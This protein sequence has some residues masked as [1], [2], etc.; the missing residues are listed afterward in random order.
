MSG[1]KY[2][3]VRYWHKAEIDDLR[4]DARFRGKSG[5]QDQTRLFPLMTQGRPAA[6]EFT[7]R[8]ARA[9]SSAAEPRNPEKLAT[10]A[11]TAAHPHRPD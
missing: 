8:P 2:G 7:L 6:K 9:A 11:A 10:L 4:A 5:H 1:L 3:D